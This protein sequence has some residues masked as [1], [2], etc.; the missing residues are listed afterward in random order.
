MS[1]VFVST[2]TASFPFK[3]L[4]E[5]VIDFY[6]NKPSAEVVIQSGAYK[7]K[8]PKKHI[9]IQPYFPFEKMI[10]FFKEA[11]VIISAAGEAT[12]F[13]ILES[14][15]NQPIIVPRLK[16]H[17]EHVDDQQLQI[18]RYL[19]KAKL[20]SIVL[21]IDKLETTLEN[22]SLSSNPKRAAKI[23]AS[24]EKKRLIKNLHRLTKEICTQL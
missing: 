20:A 8:S 21:D 2:G 3:R 22:H 5:A 10:K 11:D 1:L 16:K 17:G 15:V 18:A 13:S 14:A 4:V 24:S 9:K 23:K 7:K 19:K 12:V 6:E